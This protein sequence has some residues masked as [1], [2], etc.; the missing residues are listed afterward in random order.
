MKR[1][2]WRSMAIVAASLAL[3]ACGAPEEEL[4]A[5]EIIARHVEAIGGGDAIEAFANIR[6]HPEVVE[7]EFTVEGD[8]R[9]TRDG[10]VRVDIFSGEERVFSEGIDSEGGW[11]QP[12]EGGAIEPLTEDGHA[13]LARGIEFNI[14]G[15]HN[16]AERGHSAALHGRE[17]VD[18][19]NYYVIELTMADG[20]QRYFYI[21]PDNWRIERTREVSAL[22]PD[23]DS[24]ERPA[25]TIFG[26]FERHC[27]VLINTETRKVDLETDEEI[28][29][30]DAE[31]VSCNV[32]PETLDIS[33]PAG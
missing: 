7:P 21:N 22:H 28:Q 25:E 12:G 5:D 8:Y 6:V 20:F 15:L 32:D 23:L 10:L 27:G 9:A 1:H 17:I 31:V 13:A 14:F 11:Q 33:R 2:G 19:V 24:E 16:L 3:A 30:T 4:T 26:G 29:R 18:D